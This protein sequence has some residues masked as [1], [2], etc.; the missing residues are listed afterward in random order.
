MCPRNKHTHTPASDPQGC[1]RFHINKLLR[2]VGEGF[3]YET[4]RLPLTLRGE[5]VVFWRTRGHRGCRG[6][7][8]L[9]RLYLAKGHVEKG[10][11]SRHPKRH[12]GAPSTARE[13]RTWL[14]SHSE[15]VRDSGTHVLLHAWEALPLPE[16]EAR[17]LSEQTPDPRVA[18]VSTGHPGS[19]GARPTRM[20]YCA[21][22]SRLSRRP[23]AQPRSRSVAV[24]TGSRGG[25]AAP[26]R[27]LFL[28]LP[29]PCGHVAMAT[30][31]LSSVA[32]RLGWRA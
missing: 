2:G 32:S 20:S 26:R 13:A 31:L 19:C 4:S 3:C 5:N 21:C 23:P 6:F 15:H 25:G 29:V 12:S 10:T 18:L 1:S 16:A 27:L 17:R 28:P 7:C 9:C 22:A 24:A 11:R 30:E 8:V 14:C